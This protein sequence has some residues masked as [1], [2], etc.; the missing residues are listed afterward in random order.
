MTSGEGGEG[1]HRGDGD[2]VGKATR[3]LSSLNNLDGV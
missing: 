3:I 2:G 1:D